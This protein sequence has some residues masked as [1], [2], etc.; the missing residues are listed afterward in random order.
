MCTPNE[1]LVPILL[2]NLLA[3]LRGN[4]PIEWHTGDGTFAEMVEKVWY[5]LGAKLEVEDHIVRW[6][7]AR[8]RQVACALACQ[9]IR[10][11]VG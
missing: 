3:S 1:D 11:V 8:D 5:G 2:D 10:S 7:I 6:T 4:G 9:V